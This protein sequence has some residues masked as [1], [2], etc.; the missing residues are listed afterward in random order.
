MESI[1]SCGA[2]GF[3]EQLTTSAPERL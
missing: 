3:T 2:P 1:S